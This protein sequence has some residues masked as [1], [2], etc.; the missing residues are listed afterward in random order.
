M[1]SRAISAEP[2]LA[3]RAA[4]PFA[5]LTASEQNAP[6][7][8]GALLGAGV[9]AIVGGS[10]GM[11]SGGVVGAAAGAGIGA[12]VGALAGAAIGFV[13]AAYIVV[14]DCMSSPCGSIFGTNVMIR[15]P[16]NASHDRLAA[17]LAPRLAP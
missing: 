12:L 8:I 15:T 17:A 3:N 5:A 16:G 11:A 7:W 10:I 13:V 9:G 6:V 4:T 14:N 2:P 1:I